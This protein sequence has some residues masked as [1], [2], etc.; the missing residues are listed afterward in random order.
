MRRT[1]GT[2]LLSLG[3]VLAVGCGDSD[4]TADMG[5]AGA[6]ALDEGGFVEQPACEEID[7]QDACEAREDCAW[8]SIMLLMYP[9]Q[10]HEYCLSLYASE[11]PGDPYC[12]V[13]SSDGTAVEV[14]CEETEVPGEE[15]G[16]PGVS[17]GEDGGGSGKPDDPDQPPGTITNCEAIEDAETCDAAEGCQWIAVELQSYPPQ[18]IEGCFPVDGGGEGGDCGVVSSDGTVVPCEPGTE[19]GGE[20]GV[21]PGGEGD[22][23]G[24]FDPAQP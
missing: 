5:G 18:V 13:V 3:L 20:P 17:P 2:A 9:P 11:E 6:D 10:I 1:L 15:P 12:A 21:E 24:G 4:L 23:G 8:E 14:P 22:S 16:G 19:P 7:D